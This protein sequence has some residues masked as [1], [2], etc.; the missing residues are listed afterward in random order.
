MFLTHHKRRVASLDGA[1]KFAIDPENIGESNG[2]YNGLK[3]YEGAIVPSV[4]NTK[5]GLLDYEGAAWYERDFYT[6][7]GTLRFAFGA[8][9]TKADV[10]LDGEKNASHYGGFSSFEAFAL[11]EEGYHTLTVRADNR[12]DAD[13]IPQAKVDWYHYG[14]I[15]RGVTM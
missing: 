11:L 10:W 1:W 14:G 3:E 8:V 13:S 7:G 9:M 12:F 15:V 5:L 4:W 6:D 2:W